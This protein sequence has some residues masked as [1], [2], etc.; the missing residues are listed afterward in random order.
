MPAPGAGAM[1]MAPNDPTPRLPLE[2]DQPQHQPHRDDHHR[3]GQEDAPDLAD[4]GKSEIDDL[5][6]RRA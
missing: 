4:I 2:F 6:W 3:A 5:L 1:P